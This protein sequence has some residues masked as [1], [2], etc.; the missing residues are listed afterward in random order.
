VARA[1]LLRLER[2]AP[3]QPARCDVFHVR[4]LWSGHGF[5]LALAATTARLVLLRHHG[6]SAM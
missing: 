3:S 2:A 5:P 6:W 1:R 4:H